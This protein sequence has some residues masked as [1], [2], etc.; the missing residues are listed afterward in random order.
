[1]IKNTELDQM[2]ISFIGA[3]NMAFALIKGML[4]KGIKAARIQVSD[5]SQ[6]RLNLVQSEWPLKTSTDNLTACE[7]ADIVILAVKPQVL[8]KVLEEIAP[9]LSEKKPLIISIAAGINVEKIKALTFDEAAIVR[10]MPNTPAMVQTGA[11]GLFA[12]S[13]VSE[14]QKA[15]ASDLLSAVGLVKWVENEALI[16]SVTALSGSGPA[17]FFYL[18]ESMIAAGKA[19]GLDETTA[20]D[21]TLQTALGAA[22]LAITSGENPQ[23][24]R[25]NVTSPG[26]TTE[27]ALN[28][29]NSQNVSEDIQNAL[30]AA[31]QRSIELSQK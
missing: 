12:N 7:R 4:S 31:Q 22:H 19:L 28:Y 14:Q 25:K 3:G 16:D 23:Q 9:V 1:M 8:D 2:N 24:L 18:M 13:F 29:L 27:A 26:G 17:Y 15:I 10:A 21:L 11:T 6:E 5:K 30:K 20:K